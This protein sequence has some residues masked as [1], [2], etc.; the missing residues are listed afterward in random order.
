MLHRFFA[1]IFLICTMAGFVSGQAEPPPPEPK[2]I[3]ADDVVQQLLARLSVAKFE[4]AEFYGI[5]AEL[6]SHK[7]R[8]RDAGGDMIEQAALF[9]SRPHKRQVLPYVATAFKRDRH[10]QLY[11]L[12]PYY[13]SSDEG[14]RAVVK[15]LYGGAGRH[16]DELDKQDEVVSA[17]GFYVQTHREDPP[18]ALVRALFQKAPS[19]AFTDL[20]GVWSDGDRNKHRTL[21]LVEHS[22]QDVVWKASMQALKNGEVSAVESELDQLS[23]YEEWWVRLYV[24]EMLCR[25]DDI[26]PAP[27]IRDRLRNDPHPLV[28]ETANARFGHGM[29]DDEAEAAG[30]GGDRV[31]EGKD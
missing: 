19:A 26:F 27:K 29:T 30:R 11:K 7:L 6:K 24:A 22:V 18:L 25:H 10:A 4:S 8:L 15:R 17:L 2:T 31:R 13:D 1:P 5:L 12:L 16:T 28:V 3:V 21:L 14:L 23:R 9:D 20:A